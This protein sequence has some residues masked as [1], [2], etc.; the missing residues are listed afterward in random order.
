MRTPYLIAGILVALG[1]IM[2]PVAHAFTGPGTDG[3]PHVQGPAGKP[4]VKGPRPSV[5]GSNA[6]DTERGARIGQMPSFKEL[7]TERQEMRASFTAALK[8]KRGDAKELFQEHRQETIA[9]IQEAREEFKSRIEAHREEMKKLME[10]RREELKAKLAAFKDGKKAEIA[11]RVDEA[12]GDI[13]A[14]W[15]ES[16]TNSVNRIEGVLDAIGSRT[17]KAE[18]AGKDVTAVRAKI[19][20][21]HGAIDAARAAIEAQADKDYTLE[22][23]SEATVKT[24]ASGTRTQLRTDLETVRKAVRA[25]YDATKAAAAALKA[26]PGIGDVELAA[27]STTSTN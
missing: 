24:D 7:R 5:A 11:E 26:V 18:A 23:S 22:V 1:L 10:T 8:E 27:S 17:D 15:I 14:R 13:N 9:R 21:A 3:R 19:E 16:F 4:D 25:A 12:F 6:T 2:N 20:T